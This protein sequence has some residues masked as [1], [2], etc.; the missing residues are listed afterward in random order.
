MWE[1]GSPAV[2]IQGFTPEYG[3]VEMGENWSDSECILKVEPKGFADEWVR[4]IK[5]NSKVFGLSTR[6]DGI[7]IYWDGEK[8][9]WG[10]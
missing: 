5:S 7:V 1:A 6:K 10:S 2:E 9:I 8:R 3:L 4:G